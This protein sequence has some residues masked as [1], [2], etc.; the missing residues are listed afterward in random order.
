M[1]SEQLSVEM[2]LN[3]VDITVGKVLTVEVD[4]EAFDGTL[5]A[6]AHPISGSVSGGVLRMVPV[7][8]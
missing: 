1:E 5:D 3:A 7:E 4:F 8:L 6:G 2:S